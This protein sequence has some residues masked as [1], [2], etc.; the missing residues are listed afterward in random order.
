[1]CG[2]DVKG[3]LWFFL[4]KFLGV[5][6]AV[7]RRGLRGVPGQNK[8]TREAVRRVEETVNEVR[9]RVNDMSSSSRH[10]PA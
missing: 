9:L 4:R 3:C 6:A 5:T 1:M 8:D 7:E 2:E 10:P